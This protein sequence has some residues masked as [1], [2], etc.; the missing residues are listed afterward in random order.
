M[1]DIIAC[2]DGSR[3]SEFVCDY[4]AWASRR[5]GAPLTLLHVI[6][7]P[8]AES[9]LDLSG[10]LGLGSRE[11]LLEEMVELEERRGILLREQG[12]ALLADAEQRVQQDGIAQPARLLRHGT[13]TETLTELQG[14][15]RLVVL[16]KQGR[17]G[18]RIERHIGSHLESII[19]TLQRPLLVSPL[20]YR[21][22]E[23]FLIAYDGSATAER[24]VEWV[25]QSTL[26]RGLP[27]HLLMAAEENSTTRE[28]LAQAH[29]RLATHGFSVQSHLRP[30]MVEE[31]LCA[32]RKEFDIHL[33]VMGAYGHSRLRQF[34]VGSTTTR[35]IMESPMPLL[36]LR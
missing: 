17:E 19:R 5:L 31:V 7:N 28:Q 35:M 21:E 27:A 3:S 30:G 9:H 20:R 8:H 12:K 33:V 22:P 6:H 26:L 34:F 36:I 16:G 23:C 1:N 2:I 24:M 11:Q 25:A 10:S 13:I 18:E 15:A 14:Q 32:F 4:A 29:E